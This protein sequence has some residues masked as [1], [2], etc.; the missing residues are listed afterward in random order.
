MRNAEAGMD[1]QY[2]FQESDWK[3]FRAKLQEWH[4]AYLERMNREYAEILSKPGKASDK[5]RAL[6]KRI[7]RDKYT[8]SIDIRMSHSNMYYHLTSLLERGVIKPEDLNDFSSELRKQL[9]FVIKKGTGRTV[10]VVEEGT[11]RTV[12]WWRREP[13]EPSPWW[14]NI[15]KDVPF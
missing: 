14:R 5:F 1:D 9:D 13:G 12:P 4:E 6:E 2:I 3:T 7:N 10:P 11:G 8:L 15:W